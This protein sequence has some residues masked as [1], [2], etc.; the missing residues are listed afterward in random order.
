MIT[1]QHIFTLWSIS[2]VILVFFILSSTLTET[3][4]HNLIILTFTPLYL[5]K[6]PWIYFTTR[7]NMQYIYNP[8]VIIWYEH[9]QRPLT[10]TYW[11]D[12]KNVNCCS[13][14][15]TLWYAWMKTVLFFAD[16]VAGSKID[17][18]IHVY[19]LL[20]SPTNVST[21]IRP[22]EKYDRMESNKFQFII[23]W[24]LGTFCDSLSK[25]LSTWSL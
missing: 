17:T 16:L 23:K 14:E 3:C 1:S 2:S 5:E 8:C 18:I 9:H 6:S 22:C 10:I 19:T 20:Y 24:C 25:S 15:K 11:A 21:Q 7:I 12:I 4:I 13:C